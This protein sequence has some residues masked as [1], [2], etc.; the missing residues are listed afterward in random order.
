M[1]LHLAQAFSNRAPKLRKHDS[2]DVER[3]RRAARGP[4]VDLDFVPEP[5]GLFQQPLQPV[6]QLDYRGFSPSGSVRSTASSTSARKS[7]FLVDSSRDRKRFA[8]P[9]TQGKHYAKAISMALL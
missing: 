2:P 9:F 7:G 5:E 3:L 1:R 8:P 4:G 6:L